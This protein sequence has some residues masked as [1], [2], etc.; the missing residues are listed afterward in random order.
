MHLQMFLWSTPP[1][2]NW[3]TL[4]TQTSDSED[5]EEDEEEEESSETEMNWMMRKDARPSSTM[6]NW[7]KDLYPWPVMKRTYTKTFCKFVDRYG[8]DAFDKEI[9]KMG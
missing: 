2:K 7:E 9:V 5:E 6:Y 4:A 3:R 1:Q 8:L